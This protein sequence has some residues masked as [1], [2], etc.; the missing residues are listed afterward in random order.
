[1]TNLLRAARQPRAAERHDDYHIFQGNQYWN[2]VLSSWDPKH[3]GIGSD[4][5]TLVSK[6]YKGNAIV[7]ACEM[8]RMALVSEARPQWRRIR[9]GR[10]GDLFGT[11][12]LAVL[13]RPWPG[14]TFRQLAARMVLNADMAGTAFVARR[15]EQPD[16]LMMMRPDWVVMVLGSD[17]DPEGAQFAMDA[18]LLGV[19]YYPGGQGSG[20]DPIPLLSDEVA[21]WAPSPDPTAA[22]RGVSWLSAVAREVDSD[23]A[24]TVHKAKFFE[25]G[26]TPQLIISM[27]PEVKK[28]HFKDFVHKMEASHTGVANAYRTLM[29]GAGAT[30]HVVGKDMQQLDFRNTQGAG[31]T[32][33]A[34]AS[35]VHPVVAALSEGMAGSSLNAGNF[36]AACRLVADRTLRPLWGG[37]FAALEQIVPPPPD[38]DLW[39]AEKE[40]S[41]LQEDRKDAAEIEFTKAQT[42]GQLVREGFE[43]DS[44]IRAVEAEDMNLLIHSGLVSVQLQPPGTGKPAVEGQTTE[45]PGNNPAIT[46]GGTP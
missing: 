32:R 29:L 14:G 20:R 1:M 12:D 17:A 5:A 23:L 27:G 10:R 36:R 40:I 4:F 37:L 2:N 28:E 43:P 30:P 22:Y 8:T 24:A 7:Y 3:E 21:V 19:L 11:Q 13:E 9:N 15:R 35:G 34:A 6:A 38:A 31:E 46:A 39:Y 42:I 41:F 18:D 16:R 26:A 25:N 45:Q 44:V 33:M